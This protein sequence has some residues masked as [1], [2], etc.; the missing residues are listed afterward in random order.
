VLGSER[1]IEP[2]PAWQEGLA[3]YRAIAPAV[4]AR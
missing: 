2:L 1:D 3:A 4:F